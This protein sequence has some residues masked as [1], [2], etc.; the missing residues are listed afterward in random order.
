[1][2]PITLRVPRRAPEIFEDAFQRIRTELD[3][4]L[5]F[6]AEVEEEAHAAQP[7]AVERVDARHL[8]LVAI[9]PPG[10]TDLDQAFAAERIGDGYRVHY[11]IAD[12]GAFV[13]PG[14]AVDLEARRRGSTLYC[15]DFRAPLHPTVISEDR[16]SLLP[17]T[18]KV[19]LLWTIDLDGRGE[20]TRWH[21]ERASVRVREAISYRQAQDRIDAAG[22]ADGQPTR[23]DANSV[24][25]CLQLLAE[26]GPLRQALEAQRGGVSLRL[27]AQEIAREGD[28][29]VLEFDQAIP[30]EG[31]NAQI[32]LLAGMAAG[33]TMF[34]AG[35]GVLR[36]LP[37]AQANDIAALRRTAAALGLAWPDH[38]DYADF[39]RGLHPTTPAANAFLVQCTRLFKGA[40]YYSFVDGG[41]RPEHPEHGAIAAIYSHV[42][43][44]LRRLVDRF[45][46]EIVL[47]LLAGTP[48]HRN[49]RSR[50]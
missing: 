34:D 40:G 11:A 27:P 9:D 47:A 4:P 13:P 35:I 43:A 14:G 7:A 38:V 10:A 42:T 17:G 30:V 21:L 6:P 22:A 24:D 1:M 41:N 39:V 36:T 15:P 16:A 23:G 50:H 26:I 46:N 48:H 12:V 28:H 20:A 37:G 31:W 29:Y 49:G 18:D 25:G 5:Q 45:G 44:P 8:P 32:S 33:R 3:V 19:A 2:R